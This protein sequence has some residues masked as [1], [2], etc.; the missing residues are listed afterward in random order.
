MYLKGL[1]LTPRLSTHN[2][3]DTNLPTLSKL[4]MESKPDNEPSADQMDVNH[5]VE[6]QQAEETQAIPDEDNNEDKNKDKDDDKGKEVQVYNNEAQLGEYP[7]EETQV[8]HDEPEFHKFMLLPPELRR[9]VWELA[10]PPPRYFIA[11][12]RSNVYDFPLSAINVED[13]RSTTSGLALS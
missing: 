6:H 1:R 11:Q 2:R 10:V 9:M 4:T 7:M 5:Q 13:F 3:I 12:F 8:A